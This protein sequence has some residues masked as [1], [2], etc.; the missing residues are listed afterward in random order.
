MPPEVSQTVSMGSRIGV[1]N[2]NFIAWIETQ[3]GEGNIG[4]RSGIR[5][6]YSAGVTWDTYTHA[7]T[8]MQMEAADKVG[9][10]MVQSMQRGTNKRIEEPLQFSRFTTFWW[11]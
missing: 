1:P 9:G 3:Y 11:K 4:R 10:F 8:K 6:H 2:D 5:G 7:T